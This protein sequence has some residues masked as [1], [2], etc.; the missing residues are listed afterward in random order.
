MVAEIPPKVR[1]QYEVVHKTWPC[2]FH[3]NKY[4]EKLSTNTLFS[5]KELR[6]HAAFMSVAI[7]AAK[8]AKQFREDQ[9]GAVI[10]DPK[11]N[12]IVAAGFH[13]TNEG[14]CRHAVMV[15]V[16]NVAKT[17]NG[18]RWNLNEAHIFK[19]DLNLNGFSTDLLGFLTDKHRALRFGAAWFKG[20]S[21]LEEPADG[22]YLCTGYYVYMTHEPCIMCAMGLIHSR[23]KRVFF[24]VKTARGGLETLCKIHTVK[25]LNHHYEVFGGLLEQRCS[26]L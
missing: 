19:E 11:I 18:G 6:A 22:P 8:Y 7:D 23:A 2:N 3:S 10:V 13:R 14:P 24:G 12:S 16:D 9:V 21:D 4:L 1:K 25:D 17:Q 26:E 20:K 5:E 15:A